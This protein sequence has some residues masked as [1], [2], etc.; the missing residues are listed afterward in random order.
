MIDFSLAKASLVPCTHFTMERLAEIY[1]E[2]RVDYIVPMPMNAK[3][4]AEYVHDHDVDLSESI[5]VID[6]IGRA[7][8]IGMLGLRDTRGWITRLG[9]RPDQRGRRIGHL[10]MSRLLERAKR[11]EV[12]SVQL[13]VIK[14][15][16]P[17]HALFLKCGFRPL[18]DLL[19]LNRAPSK[20]DALPLSGFSVSQLSPAEITACLESRQVGLA[21]WIDETPSL[22]NGGNLD[23]FRAVHKSGLGGWLI[24]RKSIFQLSHYV[25]HAEPG[26]EHEV[27]RSLL[28]R[29]HR[30]YSTHD[31]KLENLP[32]N[33]PYLSAFLEMGYFEVFRR[34]EMRLIFA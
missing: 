14:G 5:V 33:T 4:M 34:T 26:C 22:L 7:V 13:E 19:I 24:F 1:N 25:H 29:L 17:A 20:I 23:G 8:G 30:T 15:N 21:S 3:R 11:R 18:R 27:I 6:A 31:A 10:I 28:D 12:L 32:A 16:D 2:T 9:V